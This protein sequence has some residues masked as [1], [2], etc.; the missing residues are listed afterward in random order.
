[1][2]GWIY[3]Y[4]RSK[5]KKDIILL[6]QSQG[7][8]TE[9]TI[10]DM[11]VVKTKSK[12]GS[13]IVGYKYLCKD[14]NT[15]EEYESDVIRM[16]EFEVGS[17]VRVIKDYSRYP[18]IYWVDLNTV[19]QNSESFA[20]ATQYQ[21]SKIEA[22]ERNL[23]KLLKGSMSYGGTLALFGIMGL[24]LVLLAVFLQ[25]LPFWVVGS[26]FLWLWSMNFAYFFREKKRQKIIEKN[27]S[28]ITEIVNV[29]KASDWKTVALGYIPEEE[30]ESQG[31]D[32]SKINDGLSTKNINIY[33]YKYRFIVLLSGQSK[34]TEIFTK[35]FPE[36]YRSWARIRIYFDDFSQMG[37][38]VAD[39]ES[40]DELN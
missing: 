38:F 32:I 14:K 40:I 18:G 37:D 20:V 30:R 11:E 34:A 3:A 23:R 17:S 36:K 7:C 2:M 31:V 26:I 8:F 28:I 19:S 15:Q 29:E 33:G 24:M 21:E 4:V 39:L 16:P 9:S 25:S 10:I 22:N 5:R 6:L 35:P 1:M 13:R 12:R 27:I